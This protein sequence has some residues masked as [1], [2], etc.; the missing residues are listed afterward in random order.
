MEEKEDMCSSMT[1]V[2]YQEALKKIV[3]GMEDKKSLQRLFVLVKKRSE[4]VTDSSPDYESEIVEM[5]C[6]IENTEIL[7][8]LYTFIKLFLEKWG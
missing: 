8:Y 1:V 4:K 5:V 6:K 7:E 2:E 3:D